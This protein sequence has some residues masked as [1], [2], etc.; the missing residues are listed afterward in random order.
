LS[1]TPA[2]CTRIVF[3]LVGLAYPMGY[4]GEYKPYFTI[5]EE[6]YKDI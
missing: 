4:F 3:G 1:D 5:F 6:E 2:V